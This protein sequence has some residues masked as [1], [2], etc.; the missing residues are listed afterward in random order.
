MEAVLFLHASTSH[1][2]IL[3]INSWLL[4]VARRSPALFLTE[5]SNRTNQ[6]VAEI[7]LMPN[8]L[9]NLH[10]SI[11]KKCVKNSVH[12]V[13]DLCKT[14]FFDLFWAQKPTESTRRACPGKWQMKLK[15]LV[16][17]YPQK[18]FSRM[19]SFFQTKISKISSKWWQMCPTYKGP[20]T[21]M[22]NRVILWYLTVRTSC[23]SNKNLNS[24]LPASSVLWYRTK[25]SM[26]S[27]LCFQYKEN[28][29][30]CR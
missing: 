2:L 7:F 27:R 14:N 16:Y 25:T 8:I 12:S 5:I 15:V 29:L 17:I 22:L 18:Y 26:I 30:R 21:E 3:R 1:C 28:L 10:G 9:L 19:I 24:N 20:K 11:N 6:K 13:N 23:K 4:H